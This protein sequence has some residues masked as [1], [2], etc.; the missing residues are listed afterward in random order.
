MTGFACNL[1]LFVFFYFHSLYV[2]NMC[3]IIWLYCYVFKWHCLYSVG[4][5]PVAHSRHPGVNSRELRTGT[6]HSPRDNT[7]KS[8]IGNQWSARITL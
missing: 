6:T 8:V 1:L 7:N 4:Y 3:L 5:Y 2:M